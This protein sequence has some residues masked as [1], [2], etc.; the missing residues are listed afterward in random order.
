MSICYPEF[1][2]VQFIVIKIH[3]TFV[4]HTWSY[5]TTRPRNTY[6]GAMWLSWLLILTWSWHACI[7]CLY[8]YTLLVVYISGLQ[9]SPY[10]LILLSYF[11]CITSHFGTFQVY[12]PWGIIF[13]WA[14]L[15][16]FLGMC[17]GSF[18]I[19]SRSF[20]ALCMPHLRSIFGIFLCDVLI[21]LG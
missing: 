6:K 5:V 2:T 4:I 7:V 13:G 20:V 19:N 11:S 15:H 18:H 8:F 17:R 21:D 3:Y 12:I 14:E 10:Y 9:V 16:L 1:H